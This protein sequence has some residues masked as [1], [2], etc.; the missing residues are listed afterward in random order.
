MEYS[1]KKVYCPIFF[2]SDSHFESGWL[3]GL[4]PE[5]GVAWVP[6]SPYAYPIPD[7]T[8]QIL[9]SFAKITSPTVWFYLL[10]VPDNQVLYARPDVGLGTGESDILCFSAIR[11][12]PGIQTSLLLTKFW[13]TA[14]NRFPAVVRTRC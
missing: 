2:S 6:G 4:L 3:F 13:I 8:V 11:A 9:I 10:G 12:F 5:G 7:S 1:G 14:R